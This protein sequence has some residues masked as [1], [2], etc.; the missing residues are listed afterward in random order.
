MSV[1]GPQDTHRTRRTRLEALV[2]PM[3]RLRLGEALRSALCGL[4]GPHGALC[5]RRMSI[6]FKRVRRR[7][8][9]ALVCLAEPETRGA[10]PMGR[11]ETVW[12]LAVRHRSCKALAVLKGW[13]DGAPSKAFIID[14][15]SR[16]STVCFAGATLQKHERGVPGFLVPVDSALWTLRFERTLIRR[17]DPRC[18]PSSLRELSG[19]ARA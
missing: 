4:L 9:A 11:F 13:G 12:N 18:T 1:K 14:S 17:A 5:L 10:A 3:T 2:G 6:P 7:A 16:K 8:V 15:L 19:L